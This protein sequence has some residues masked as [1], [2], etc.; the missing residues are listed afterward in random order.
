MKKI[1]SK[2]TIGCATACD[3]IAAL[4]CDAATNQICGK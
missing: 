4:G 2:L 3:A 1:F